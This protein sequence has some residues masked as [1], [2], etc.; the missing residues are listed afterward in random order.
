[1]QCTLQCGQE[2]VSVVLITT[3]KLFVYS[4]KTFL[5]RIRPHL[6]PRILIPHFLHQ[7][8]ERCYELALISHRVANIFLN[9]DWRYIKYSLTCYAAYSSKV[10]THE[11]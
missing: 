3:F 7:L 4:F 8:T 6:E 1:V 2:I 5:E 11:G 9:P 10:L